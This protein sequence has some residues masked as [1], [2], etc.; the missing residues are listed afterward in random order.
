M[1]HIAVCV[2]GEK[3]KASATA[4]AVIRKWLNRRVGWIEGRAE[5]L[6]CVSLSA[7]YL[8]RTEQG[9]NSNLLLRF[10]SPQAASKWIRSTAWYV[11]SN[12]FSAYTA[13]DFSFDP[14]DLARPPG[15]NDWYMLM[16]L[17]L[18]LYRDAHT[19]SNMHN[20]R[21][22]S[23]LNQG[24]GKNTIPLFEWMGAGKSVYHA[25]Y[26]FERLCANAS[27]LSRCLKPLLTIATRWCATD[28][29]DTQ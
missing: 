23:T 24:N 3:R 27:P 20:S 16:N 25:R 9:Q 5:I 4:Y 11:I 6:F 18:C 29:I 19:I 2:W 13:N 1:V 10:G 28:W 17:C 22:C 7:V 12:K 26:H 8:L 14:M 21:I 15:H